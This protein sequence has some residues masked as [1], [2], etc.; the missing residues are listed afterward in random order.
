MK[1]G[2][3]ISSIIKGAVIPQI[4]PLGDETWIQIGQ[5]L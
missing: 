1:S 5:F 4:F 2:Y 3:N